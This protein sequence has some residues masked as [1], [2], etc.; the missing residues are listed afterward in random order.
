[1]NDIVLREAQPGDEL[2][3]VVAFESIQSTRP[4]DEIGGYL[5][6][7]GF[8]GLGLWVGGFDEHSAPVRALVQYRHTIRSLRAPVWLMYAGYFGV[9]ASFDGVAKVSH[10]VFYTESKRLVGPVG[11]GP[12][13]DR[14]YIAR[15][16]RF[17]EPV[18]AL[19]IIRAIPEFACECPDCQPLDELMEAASMIRPGSPMRAE[20]V[21]RLQRHFLQCRSAEVEA[22]ESMSPADAY[23]DLVRSAEIVG[24]LPLSIQRSLG[25]HDRHLLHWA[26]AIRHPLLTP[27]SIQWACREHEWVMSGQGRVAAVRDVDPAECPSD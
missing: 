7:G 9:L 13:A 17:Y 11:S 12:P 24:I 5:Q 22:I 18:R 2:W 1:M 14:Y 8:S 26:E 4:V 16:H 10:G 19:S 21:A 15:L 25:L 20:W 3:G 23:R 6:L 27:R